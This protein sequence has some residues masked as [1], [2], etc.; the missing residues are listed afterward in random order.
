MVQI[1]AQEG[2]EVDIPMWGFIPFLRWIYHS[3]LC[4]TLRAISVGGFF[5]TIHNMIDVAMASEYLHVGQSQGEEHIE[6]SRCLISMYSDRDTLS[7]R[8]DQVNMY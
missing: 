6:S 8:T 2:I 3:L 7:I 4:L 1:F 5:T